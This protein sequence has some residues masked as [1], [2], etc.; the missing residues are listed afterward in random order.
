MC[1]VES[2]PTLPYTHQRPNRRG[3]TSNGSMAPATTTSPESSS[4]RDVSCVGCGVTSV[5]KFLYLRGQGKG[6]GAQKKS[7]ERG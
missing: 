3:L 6:G 7:M 2:A 1:F 4:A 5:R